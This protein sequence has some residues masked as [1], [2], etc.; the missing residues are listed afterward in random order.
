MTGTFSRTP[1]QEVRDVWFSKPRIFFGKCNRWLCESMR[2]DEWRV[3]GNGGTPQE[4]F[5]DMKRIIVAAYGRR[6][7]RVEFVDG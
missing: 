1:R 7:S 6:S 4:A 2:A 5:E 3:V